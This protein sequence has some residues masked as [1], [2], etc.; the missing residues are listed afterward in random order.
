MVSRPRPSHG[1]FLFVPSPGSAAGGRRQATAQ[2]STAC[3]LLPAYLKP[4][5]AACALRLRRRVKP[6]HDARRAHCSVPTATGGQISVSDKSQIPPSARPAAP[7]GTHWS[8]DLLHTGLS[9][10]YG[11]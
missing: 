3:S 7:R 10:V 8:M 2:S 6:N 1:L 4:N 9:P 5:H 11:H